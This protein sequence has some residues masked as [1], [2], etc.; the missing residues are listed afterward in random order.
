ME[1]D[2]TNTWGEPTI[3]KGIKLYPIQMEKCVSFFKNVGC[4]TIQKNNISDIEIIQMSYLNFLL[5]VGIVNNEVLN[6]FNKVMSLVL[7]EQKLVFLLDDK[8]Y[9][10]NNLR[11]F[12][13]YME[14]KDRMNINKIKMKVYTDENEITITDTDFE[15]IRRIICEQNT[16]EIDDMVLPEQIQKA[17]EEA[18][19]FV[20]DGNNPTL[21]EQIIALACISGNITRM[22]EI[23]K[24]T[25]YQFITALKRY[26]LI[27]SSRV[28]GSA[29]ATGMV[30]I[31]GDI[32]TWLSPTPKQNSLDRVTESG[33]KLEEFKGMME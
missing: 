18:E 2:L 27:E 15:K 8:E 24:M 33:D 30:E 10:I 14:L 3:Y 11:D 9:D 25:I 28:Y 1:I 26:N 19:E 13:E 22:N 31:K 23:K 7:R 16:I 6:A 17:V 32:P 5:I 29:I 4:L 21:E 20:D 12:I